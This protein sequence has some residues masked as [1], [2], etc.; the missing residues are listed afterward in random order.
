MKKWGFLVFVLSILTQWTLGNDP[1]FPQPRDQESGIYTL[2]E[3]VVT[4]ER[5]GVEAIGTVREIMNEEIVRKAARTVDQ[6][7][8]LL[9]GLNIRTGADGIPR[10]D[11]RGFRSRHVQ[12]LLNGIPF[13]S[14]Y[15]GQFDPALLYVE[16]IAK[17]KIT[18]G[19][20]SVL[21]GP[22]GLGGAVNII[23]RKGT[24]GVQGFIGGEAGERGRYLG[25]ASV[26]GSTDKWD[27][28]VSG[29]G[30]KR[31]GFLLSDDF[32]PTPLQDE[33]LRENSDWE[34]YNIFGNV[35]FSPTD[36]W[37]FGLFINGLKGDFGKPPTTIDNT[38][39][40]VF[41]KRA[42][43][44]R[45]DDYEGFSTQLSVGSDLPGLF[46]IRGWLYL[47]QLD[48]IENRY[49]DDTYSTIA[50]RN[51]FHHENKTDIGGGAVQ[52]MF[53]FESA[54]FLT[55][56]LSGDKQ[57]FEQTGFDIERI[58][59]VNVTTYL[60]NQFDVETYTASA[61][62]DIYPI[63][64]LGLVFGYSYSRFDKG[65]GGEDEDGHSYLFGTHY[66]FTNGFRLR[67][68]YAR[69][70]RFPDIRQLYD[71]NGGN[72]DLKPE[73]SDNFEVGIEKSL[74]RNSRVALVGFHNDVD[75]YIEKIQVQGVDVF[76]N[77]D[78]YVFRGVELTAETRPLEGLMLRGG[79]TYMDSE[80]KTAGD[81]RE[82]LQYR[83]KHKLAIEGQ[84]VFPFGFSIYANILY[85]ADQVFYSD[86]FLSKAKLN[87]Y[88]LFNLK[89]G[90]TL[91]RNQLHLY[92]GA[93]NLFDKDYEQSY[94]FPQA[95]R[96]I[97]GGAKFVF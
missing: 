61:E 64:Q 65:Q 19:N 95:G 71:A 21:Y 44:D 86:D 82:E 28:F 55:L 97:Y 29:T 60:N 22:G 84:Y 27:F 14:A 91:L 70:I 87:D 43:F 47:N 12:L 54:G 39:D 90:Q 1:A 9:P 78:R 40:P 77:N 89:F 88:F 10:V 11:I 32:T 17:I 59:G 33:G 75:D 92:L 57:D 42:R 15:D 41:G 37:N 31:D 56:G 25:R 38:I 16:N 6:A 63:E 69:K 50:A 94:G 26:S 48:E 46:N 76:T 8:E 51:S 34:R 18:Y 72:P 5:E 83:P 30:D 81:P 62:Y 35:G 2:G 93:D 80:V 96:T 85:L 23:T 73:E 74:P 13:N 45:I 52:G 67:G 3:V 24:K 53:D 66:D 68:S 20:Q 79:Y 58:G 4:G 49:D 36:E 7:I